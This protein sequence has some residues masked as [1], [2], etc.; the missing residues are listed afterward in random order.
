[1]NSNKPWSNCTTNS[2]HMKPKRSKHDRILATTMNPSILHTYITAQYL[3]NIPYLTIYNAFTEKQ[4]LNE[5]LSRCFNG[6][7]W[8][9]LM[10][11]SVIKTLSYLMNLAHPL[12]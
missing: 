10:T 5:S 7:Q 4:A 11:V 1:M 3:N 8:L 6:C 9:G 12:L 2:H